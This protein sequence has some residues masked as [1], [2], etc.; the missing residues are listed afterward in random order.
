M[1]IS[2][3]VPTLVNPPF[4]ITGTSYYL[5]HNFNSNQ[6]V[7][8]NRHKSVR[9]STPTID[10]LMSEKALLDHAVSAAGYGTIREDND[11][12]ITSDEALLNPFYLSKYLSQRYGVE[13]STVPHYPGGVIY[14]NIDF[15]PTCINQ[16]ASMQFRSNAYYALAS[17]RL[18]WN[19]VKIT[20]TSRHPI[21]DVTVYIERPWQGITDLVEKVVVAEGGVVV[22]S[23]PFY[24]VVRFPLLL[25]NSS[26]IVVLKTR[27]APLL[28]NEVSVESIPVRTPSMLL[29]WGLSGIAFILAILYATSGI[30]DKAGRR[31][32]SII[33][34]A[35]RHLRRLRTLLGS[36]NK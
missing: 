32:F 8:L 30:W 18:L 25:S 22:H 24:Y 19:T 26:K 33:S 13:I 15:F 14:L 23:S 5:I 3:S 29:L 11:K 21:Q 1:E 27:G 9:Q 2:S 6:Y 17:S 10:E 4:L 12:T 31:F 36:K 16:I 20:N 34:A 28:D 35:I 7:T